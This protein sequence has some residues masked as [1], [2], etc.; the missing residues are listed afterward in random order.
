MDFDLETPLPISPERLA[1]L[2]DIESDHIPSSC[3]NYYSF[4]GKIVSLISHFSRNFDDPFLSYLAI[5]YLDRFLSVQPISEEKKPWILKLVSVSCISLAMKM[6]KTDC[7]IS[8]IEHD[9]GIIFDWKSI[10]RMELLILD[11]LKWRMRSITPFSF[12]N[13]FISFFKFKDFHS[14]NALKARATQIIIKAQH[15]NVTSTFIY[16]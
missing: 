16:F 7:S 3:T 5:N 13:F 15:G 10:E 14:T 6:R 8:D 9:G 1:S 11:G 4:R 12:I 2:F